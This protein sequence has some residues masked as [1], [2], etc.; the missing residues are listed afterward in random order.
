MP[1]A[2]RLPATLVSAL[3]F[4]LLGACERVYQPLPGVTDGDTDTDTDTSA[5]ETG[6]V[7][8]TEPPPD[9]SAV[10]DCEP[11][12]PTS[13]PE[14]QKCS[15]LSNGGPQN[16]F[17]CVPDDGTLPLF[18]PCVPSP[19]NGQDECGAGTVC[20]SVSEQDPSNGRCLQGCHNNSD[21]EPG[22]CATSPFTGTT[23]CAAGCDPTLADCPPGLG[24]RQSLDRFICEMV[25]DSDIGLAGEPCDGTSLRGC[26]NTYA[27][28][29]GALVPNCASASCC[30]NTC[31]TNGSPDQCV[32]PTIC[33]SL[34]LEPAPDFENTGACFVPA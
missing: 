3:S 24:C 1:A 21:C 7:T 20:L 22:V 25:L 31:D 5:G 33:K 9:P 26:A 19:E 28:M 8:S 6:P 34:F 30:T 18:E 4:L 15:A 23:F 10:Y 27:C 13:C 29:P 12:D 32:V 16:H 2:R 11:A 17:Q 14:G